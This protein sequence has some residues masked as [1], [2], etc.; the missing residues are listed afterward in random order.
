MKRKVT[1]KSRA[2]EKTF[3]GNDNGRELIDLSIYI[4]H[5]TEKAYLVSEGLTD[6]N[7][8]E[9]RCWLAKSVTEAPSHYSPNSPVDITIPRWLYEEKGFK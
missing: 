8:I 7:G 5:E 6:E 1:N 9:I 2:W 3:A 4:R